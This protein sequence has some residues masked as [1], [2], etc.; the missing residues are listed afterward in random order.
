MGNVPQ[1]KVPKMN[2]IELI[3]V[4]HQARQRY[5]QSRNILNYSTFILWYMS[6]GAVAQNELIPWLERQK[7]LKAM[8]ELALPPE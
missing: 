1:F 2:T 5:K 3:E 6:L 4:T 8:H 7:A